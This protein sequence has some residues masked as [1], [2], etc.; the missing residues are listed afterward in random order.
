[1]GGALAMYYGFRHGKGLGGIFAMSSF[2]NK[3]SRVYKVTVNSFDIHTMIYALH[4]GK[5]KTK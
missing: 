5:L 4:C 2:L 3:D 1:M